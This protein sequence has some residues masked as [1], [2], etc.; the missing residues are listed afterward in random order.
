MFYTC[1]LRNLACTYTVICTK[2]NSKPCIHFTV[3]KSIKKMRGKWPFCDISFSMNMFVTCCS[4]HFLMTSG[5]SLRSP[6]PPP[7]EEDPPEDLRGDEDE[8]SPLPEERE[9]M[10]LFKSHPEFTA[11]LL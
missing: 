9:K 1:G 4:F 11:I 8:P 3:P 2:E 6:P 5:S 10:S 7:P